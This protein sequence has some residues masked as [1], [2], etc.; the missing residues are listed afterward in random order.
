MS[1]M[2]SSL[3]ELLLDEAFREKRGRAVFQHRP[4]GHGLED[5]ELA[6]DS[7]VTYMTGLVDVCSAE[8]EKLEL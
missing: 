7:T 8:E 5:I 3:A 6:R 4:Q 1:R 2:Y